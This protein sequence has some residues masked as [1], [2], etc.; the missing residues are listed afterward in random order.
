MYMDI[1]GELS[2]VR[3]DF[4]RVSEL[5]SW[6]FL[7]STTTC[8][9]VEEE[10]DDWSADD[11]DDDDGNDELHLVIDNNDLGVA[12]VAARNEADEE[13]DEDGVMWNASTATEE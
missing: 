10:D 5:K 7:G 6:S 9:C 1:W 4:V 11:D 12:K 2:G 8:C 3:G 13:D